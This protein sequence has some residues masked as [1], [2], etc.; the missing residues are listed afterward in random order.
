MFLNEWWLLKSHFHQRN[1]LLLTA[2]HNLSILNTNFPAQSL[3]DSSRH[4][5]E[6]PK[7]YF[8]M[9]QVISILQSNSS[10]SNSMGFK[11]GD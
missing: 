7:D 4:H 5:V 9:S 11:S 1:L 3:F 10:H 8:R 6:D 2:T